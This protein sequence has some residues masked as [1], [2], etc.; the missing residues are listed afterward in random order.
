MLAWRQVAVEVYVEAPPLLTVAPM[1][2]DFG[3]VRANENAHPHARDAQHGRA[4]A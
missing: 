2:L 3:V 4:G 1:G